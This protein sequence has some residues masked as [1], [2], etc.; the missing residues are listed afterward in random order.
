MHSQLNEDITVTLT[1]YADYVIIMED[2]F[3][4]FYIDS[5]LV[6]VSKRISSSV[7]PNLRNFNTRF[8]IQNTSGVDRDLHCTASKLS[9]Q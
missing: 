9:I 5:I 8:E 6:F 4:E 1:S 2:D 7:F 3:I